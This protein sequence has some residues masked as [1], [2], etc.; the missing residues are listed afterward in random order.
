[1]ATCAYLRLS[2]GE[3]ILARL[4]ASLNPSP[5]NDMLTRF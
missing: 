2:A 3:W 5:D 4:L 1:M